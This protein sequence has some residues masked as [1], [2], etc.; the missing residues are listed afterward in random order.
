[1]SYNTNYRGDLRQGTFDSFGNPMVVALPDWE[2]IDKYA[3]PYTTNAHQAYES[4][5]DEVHAL[6]G[7]RKKK[8]VKKVPKVAPK[9]TKKKSKISIKKL[10]KKSAKQ[11]QKRRPSVARLQ[12]YP[13]ATFNINDMISVQKPKLPT[14]KATKKLTKKSTKKSTKAPAKPSNKAPVKVDPTDVG[15]DIVKQV[16]KGLLNRIDKLTVET[17]NGFYNKVYD[18]LAPIAGTI[19][20]GKFLLD[21]RSVVLSLIKDLFNMTSE[22]ADAVGEFLAEANRRGFAPIESSDLQPDLPVAL[23][24]K[25]KTKGG[26]MA[27]SFRETLKHIKDTIPF[28]DIAKVASVAIPIVGAMALGHSNRGMDRR[29]QYGMFEGMGVRRGRSA[30][31][32]RSRAPSRSMSRGK[33]G[34]LRSALKAVKDTATKH[35]KALKTIGAVGTALGTTALTG[36]NIHKGLTQKPK[37]TREQVGIPMFSRTPSGYTKPVQYISWQPEDYE[38]DGAGLTHGGGA[39]NDLIFQPF[40]DWIDGGELKLTKASKPIQDEFDS[41]FHGGAYKGVQSFMDLHDK[42]NGLRGNPFVLSALID[43]ERNPTHEE[44][45]GGKRKKRKAMK[46]RVANVVN[47]INRK[48]RRRI[49]HRLNREQGKPTMSDEVPYEDEYEKPASLKDLLRTPRHPLHE[50]KDEVVHPK[51][52]VLSPKTER[53]IDKAVSHGLDTIDKVGKFIKSHKELLGAGTAIAGLMALLIYNNKKLGKAVSEVLA[54][55][56]NLAEEHKE[57]LALAVDEVKEEAPILDNIQASNPKI[58]MLMR[59]YNAVRGLFQGTSDE[60]PAYTSEGELNQAMAESLDGIVNATDQQQAILDNIKESL[61][62]DLMN[63][64]NRRNIAVEKVQERLRN[65]APPR[66]PPIT[67][68]RLPVNWSK[69]GK[70]EGTRRLSVSEPLNIEDIINIYDNNEDSNIID[71][72]S[73]PYYATAST[74]PR[75]RRQ[76]QSSGLGF[77]NIKHPSILH[78]IHGLR[79][80]LHD[81][82]QKGGRLY[83]PPHDTSFRD[84]YNAIDHSTWGDIERGLKT[85]K[86]LVDPFIKIASLIGGGMKHEDALDAVIAH[87]LK[88]EEE[89]G[90]TSAGYTSAG[91][92]INKKGLKVSNVDSVI[93]H[94]ARQFLNK[95]QHLNPHDKRYNH[96]KLHKKVSH[97]VE[98]LL[99]GG[100]TIRKA[101][102]D[103]QEVPDAQPNNKLVKA[104]Y[105][106]LE[107]TKDPYLLHEKPWWHNLKELASIIPV[108][109]T[110]Y[111]FMKGRKSPVAGAGIK[112]KPQLTK[113]QKLKLKLK[114]GT[115]S[116]SYADGHQTMGGRSN[117]LVDYDPNDSTLVHYRGDKYY[118]ADPT[119]EDLSAIGD[120]EDVSILPYEGDNEMFAKPFNNAT[121]SYNN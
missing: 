95:L 120:V 68:R 37:P 67:S 44:L 1:M 8:A 12:D 73:D 15:K 90:Y 71:L 72:E 2:E 14:K 4:E 13:S 16:D 93:E 66:T 54:N 9:D 62:D 24:V 40:L 61:V 52:V 58:N 97:V 107:K 79:G 92:K 27:G 57:D 28:K 11:S 74:E 6:G 116:T 86:E 56:P 100:A 32:G 104:V 96:P 115:F 109:I 76:S 91:A 51:D 80:V 105:N 77:K 60:A 63:E 59:A 31:R 114:G 49:V 98:R 99:K 55:V 119:S 117:P 5:D 81:E 82:L 25:R 108:A 20:I 103:A 113:T 33:G 48:V 26:A 84:A 50:G 34:S 35:S 36:Y 43:A 45:N 18:N 83:V 94:H 41:M 21:N 64:Q 87:Q 39:W 101:V 29:K 118:R 53:F 19:T 70:A 85:S 46:K 111:S 75:R 121:Y 106:E 112:Y 89:G 69:T 10:S 17:K 22:K 42:K 78:L 38:E 88:N 110:V 102:V 3:Q 7:L 30:S 65:V 23:P 47:Q